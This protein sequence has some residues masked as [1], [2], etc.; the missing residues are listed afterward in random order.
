MYRLGLVDMLVTQQL[1]VIGFGLTPFFRRP[2]WLYASSVKNKTNKPVAWL[3]RSHSNNFFI[4]I[5]KKKT[6]H[7][8]LR[9]EYSPLGPPTCPQPPAEKK[10]N[11]CTC[12]SKFLM[13]FLQGE[14]ILESLSTL[15]ISMLSIRNVYSAPEVINKV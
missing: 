7:N 8:F 15:M 14:N 5:G 6:Q 12:R 1:T 2:P 9:N 13:H 11:E 4:L 10:I 3:C